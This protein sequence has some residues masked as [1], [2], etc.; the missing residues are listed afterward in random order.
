MEFFIFQFCGENMQLVI[1]IN[2]YGSV[3]LSN[4]Q[5]ENNYC[6]F[7]VKSPPTL[8]IFLTEKGGVG[9]GGLERH[10]MFKIILYENP[11]MSGGG[12]LAGPTHI[13]G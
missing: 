9:G 4:F 1:W 6:W 10:G 13:S 2:A 11:L 5:K 3:T 12:D 8:E 7:H